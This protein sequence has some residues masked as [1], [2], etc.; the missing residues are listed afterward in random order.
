MKIFPII[1]C[2]SLR[3]KNLS[4]RYHLGNLKCRVSLERSLKSEGFFK[5]CKGCLK[6]KV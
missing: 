5:D 6:P 3:E 2:K 4:V 1:S